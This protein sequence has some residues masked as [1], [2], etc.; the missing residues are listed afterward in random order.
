VSVAKAG[1]ITTLNARSS[2]LA[3][4]NPIDSRWNEK[5]P[6]AQNID[7]PP[8]LLSRQVQFD[9]V[10]LLLD[11]VDET[12]DRRLARHLVSLYL[13]D[14]PISAVDS[15]PIETFTKYLSYAR[16]HVQ[17]EIDDDAAQ[18]LVESYVELRGLGQHRRITATTRQLESMIRLSEA[19]ARMRLSPRV[20]ASD[21]HEASRL[22]R[23]AMKTS[24]TDPRTGLIDMDLIN[25]GIGAMSRTQ[26]DAMK[27]EVRQLLVNREASSVKWSSLLAELTAQSQA[28]SVATSADERRRRWL[29]R[30]LRVCMHTCM[31]R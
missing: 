15:L 2:I 9:L 30:V 26:L 25:T 4:A 13:E 8:P 27:R 28:V 18:L 17:P 1:I 19:H 24:A 31:V 3:C 12:R 23:A 6:V 7:L 29:T 21:V 20:E 5:L 10:Y 14:S 16:T 11:K 22:L